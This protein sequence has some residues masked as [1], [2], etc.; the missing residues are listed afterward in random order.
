M[1]VLSITIIILLSLYFYKLGDHKEKAQEKNRRKIEDNNIRN[2]IKNIILEKLEVSFKKNGYYSLPEDITQKI[3]ETIYK[4][5]ENKYTILHQYKTLKEYNKLE[6]IIKN[7]IEK[8]IQQLEN[9]YKKDLIFSDEEIQNKFKERI[10]DKIY[11][12]HPNIENFSIEISDDGIKDSKELSYKNIIKNYAQNELHC[13]EIECR[14]DAEYLKTEINDFIEIQNQIINQEDTSIFENITDIRDSL[15]DYIDILDFIDLPTI[16]ISKDIIPKGYTIKTYCPIVKPI[17]EFEN[18]YNYE[19]VLS[20]WKKTIFYDYIISNI[21]TILKYHIDF[22][23]ALNTI[24]KKIDKNLNCGFSELENIDFLEPEKYIDKIIPLVVNSCLNKIEFP[25]YLHFNWD[26]NYDKESS[27]VLIDINMP[28]TDKFPCYKNCKQIT[29]LTKKIEFNILSKKE[30]DNIYEDYIL[31]LILNIIDLIFNIEIPLIDD[32]DKKISDFIKSIAINGSVKYLDESDGHYKESCILSILTNKND[33]SKIDIEN[34]NYKKCFH[35]LKGLSSSNLSDN[36]SVTPIM[37][38]NKEDKRFIEGKNIINHIDNSVNIA[39]MDWQDFENLV[40]DIFEQE[41]CSEGSE[42]RITQSSHDGGVDAVVFDPDP[43]KGGKIVIQAK[44]YTNVVHV[45]AVRD[46][47][48]TV[49]NEGANKGIL[50]TT[51]N[52]G[53]DSYNFAKDKPITLINGN[54]L[55]YLLEKHNVKAKIDIQEAKKILC[56]QNK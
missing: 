49:V 31:S 16:T 4:E 5:A 17:K 41:Y 23:N 40:R 12:Q 26:I 15:Q 53:A 13:T 30:I 1:P 32:S 56:N 35:R 50:V 9:K 8:G 55:L 11:S 6:K 46:L 48:G 33:F 10:I 42:V 18:R 25:E 36:V 21:N 38:F 45:S 39:A 44:R 37:Q 34:V 22:E 20:N 27:I 29:K 28:T 14:E 54:Q 51:S 19:A 52:F 7:D 43:I 24:T 2:I 3:D 47:Y